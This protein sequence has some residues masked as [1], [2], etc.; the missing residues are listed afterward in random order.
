MAVDDFNL[1]AEDDLQRIE[2]AH[3]GIR[4]ALVVPIAYQGQVA[5][6]IHLHGRTARLF[7]ET[8]RQIG[9]SLAIQAAIALGNANRYREQVLRSELLNRRVETLSKLY[10]S[11]QALQTE[12]KLDLALE[13]IAYG[14]QSAT[15]FEVVLISV[16]DAGTHNLQRAAGAGIPLATLAELRSRPQPWNS[17]LAL[18]EERF[19]LGKAFFIPHEQ[20]TGNSG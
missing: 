19:K 17:V 11:S 20:T 18:L 4:S 16:Y 6:L 5:G 10:E 3:P 1:A 2:P 13:A 14:I 7:D 9:E 15:P 12:A 8:A